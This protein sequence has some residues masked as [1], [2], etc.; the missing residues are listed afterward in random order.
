MTEPWRRCNANQQAISQTRHDWLP[1]SVGAGFLFQAGSTNKNHDAEYPCALAGWT[2]STPNPT[3]VFGRS[4]IANGFGV[5]GMSVGGDGVA[6][7]SSGGGPSSAGLRGVFGQYSIAANRSVKA[8]LFLQ[9]NND[10][11]GSS[12]KTVP[13]TRSDAH[14]VGEM[15]NVDGDLW[16]CVVAGTPGTWRKIS[17]AGSAGA[18]HALTPGRVYD[19]RQLLPSSGALASGSGRTVSVADRRNAALTTGAV[20]EANFVPAGATAVAANVTITNTVSSGYLV[21]NPGGITTVGASTINWSS[22]NLNLANGVILTLD[23]ARQLTVVA[24]GGGS[25]DFIIDI[26]GYYL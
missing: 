6:G 16:W 7:T 4:T 22:S 17:G 23:A 10:S 9:P 5:V 19:S 20:V 21:C 2:T 26:T 25:T 18:F 3:G 11:I 13:S 1:L 8:N 15:E 24:G 14:L 12:P